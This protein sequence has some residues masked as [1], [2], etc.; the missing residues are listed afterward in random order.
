MILSQYCVT[1]KILMFSYGLI[2]CTVQSK[3]IFIALCSVNCERWS[4]QKNLNLDLKYCYLHIIITYIL[5][6]NAEYLCNELHFTFCTKWEL[7]Y[8]LTRTFRPSTLFPFLQIIGYSSNKA[9]EFII[10]VPILI[11]V[12]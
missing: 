7:T 12:F 5:S 10:N 11:V 8:N 3:V 4:L 1:H 2:T 6:L 9:H